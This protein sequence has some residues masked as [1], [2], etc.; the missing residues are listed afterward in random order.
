MTRPER[1]ISGEA[2][3]DCPEEQLLAAVVLPLCRHAA[4]VAGCHF[5]DM[6]Q[7]FP[8]G[9]CV[10]RFCS[11]S[12]DKQEGEGENQDDTQ[13]GVQDTRPYAAPEEPREGPE[14]GVRKDEAR[15]GWQRTKH[16]ATVQWFAR[17]RAL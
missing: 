10:M 15:K 7:P 9:G 13:N 11:R 14:G 5:P 1:A 2:D 4:V 6:L 12:L 17:S 16:M 3:G 8:I